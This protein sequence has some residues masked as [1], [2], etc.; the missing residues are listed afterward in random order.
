LGWGVGLLVHG[1][2]AFFFNPGAQLREALVQQ[3]RDRI[4]SAKG[5]R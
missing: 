1:F 3:E 2:V 4:A 5:P